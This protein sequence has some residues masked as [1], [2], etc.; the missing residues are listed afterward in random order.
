MARADPFGHHD[1]RPSDACV[2][3][4]SGGSVV[5][6][7]CNSSVSMLI[8]RQNLQ[9]APGTFRA[10][11]DNV[12]RDGRPHLKDS[13]QALTGCSLRLSRRLKR[14][15]HT[16]Y[17]WRDERSARSRRGGQ[18]DQKPNDGQPEA[19]THSWR[20]LLRRSETTLGKLTITFLDFSYK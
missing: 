4:I 16:A 1:C 14:D 20:T 10:L 5:C 19:R 12:V 7:H 18:T 2:V 6:T 8:N 13:S 9:S 15:A 3:R 11:N 17:C